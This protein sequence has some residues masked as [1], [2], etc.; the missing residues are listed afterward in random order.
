MH[1]IYDIY[2]LGFIIIQMTHSS[3]WILKYDEPEVVNVI[4]RMHK[5]LP[6]FERFKDFWELPHF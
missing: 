5:R 6:I 4:Y 3:E 2:N 1:A